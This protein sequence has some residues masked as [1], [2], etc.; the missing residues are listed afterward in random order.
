M[1]AC[2][3]LSLDVMLFAA[4]RTHAIEKS[5]LVHGCCKHV[6]APLRRDSKKKTLCMFLFFINLL[7]MQL[8]SPPPL[9]SIFVH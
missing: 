8:C 4:V 3:C 2:S 1:G 5:A 9:I 7:V 6:F